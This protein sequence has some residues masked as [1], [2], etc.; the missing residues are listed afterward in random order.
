MSDYALLMLPSA[1][2]VYAAA[3]AD[4]TRAELG[5][6]NAC[7]LGGR[8]G[9][10]GETR[11]GGVGYVT[12][13]T[14]RL[15][16][17]DIALLANASTAYALFERRGEA[18]HPIEL[19]RSDQFDDDLITIP[20]YAGKTNEQFTKLLLNVTMLSGSSGARLP[21]AQPDA[22]AE[23]TARRPAGQRPRVLDPLCGRGT[24]LNQVVTYG[25]DAAG[26]E[27]DAKDFD[28]YAAF[29]RTYLTR[30]KIKHQ[31]QVNPV[32]R[33]RRLVARRLNARVGTDPDTYRAGDVIDIDVVQADTAQAGDFFRPETFDAVVTD[34]PYG[35][36]HGGRTRTGGLRR[37][38]L[39]LLSQAVPEWAALLRPGGTMGIAINTHV[40]PRD[41]V[42]GILADAGLTV[43]DSAPYLRFRHWVD[44]AITR[45]V[46]IAR[47][48]PS[49]TEQ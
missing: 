4:L 17:R 13:T 7:G 2:R 25:F 32:R 43:L 37:S 36:A 3:A 22:H 35:V 24:T 16:S 38:P 15:T 45:D 12:F 19:T 26:L 40:S 10:I 18:L 8:L 48:A 9:E 41:D 44:Q 39:E 6:F 42:S 14:D 28:A 31:L 34:A 11:I 46:V 20:K 29:L 27:I 47:R 23:P 49:A 1:N 21:G 33:D 30:K 5:V